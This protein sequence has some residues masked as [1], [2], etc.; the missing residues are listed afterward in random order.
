[1][2]NYKES[3]VQGTSFRRCK[4]IQFINQLNV[5]TRAVVFEE[6]D[7]VSFDGK[8]FATASGSL[9][10]GFDAENGSTVFPLVDIETGALLGSATYQQVYE[11]LASLYLH[12]AMKRDAQEA[13]E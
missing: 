6:E 7:V 10:S 12:T 13:P 1:M 3:T 5:S 11:M 9:M 4:G 2:P 8:H